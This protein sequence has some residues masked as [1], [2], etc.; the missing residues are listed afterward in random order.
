MEHM[1][2]IVLEQSEFLVLLDAVKADAV[3][4]METDYILPATAEEHKAKV[5]AGLEKLV[6]TYG[7]DYCFGNTITL[8]DVL[9]IPQMAN[10]K[11]FDTDLKPFPRLSRIND[12][13]VLHPA[14]EAAAPDNQPDKT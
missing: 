4:G 5:R 14:F 1:D 7:G 12:V 3:I 11:R 6:E 13:L 8:A 2:G 10:A 9:L